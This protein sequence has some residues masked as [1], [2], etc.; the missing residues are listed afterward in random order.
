MLA[1]TSAAGSATFTRKPRP[2]AAFCRSKAATPAPTR[3]SQFFSSKAIVFIRPM[4]I[5]APALMTKPMTL[6]PL[7][8][9]A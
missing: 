2:S 5:T 4:S 8:R 7:P 3:T 9:T 6:E 1:H